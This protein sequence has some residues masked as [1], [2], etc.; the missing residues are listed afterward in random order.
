MDNTKLKEYYELMDMLATSN[1]A[2]RWI[3][4]GGKG[5]FKNIAR[6]NEFIYKSLMIFGLNNL[7][8]T[9]DF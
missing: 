9:D 2:L 7:G 8:T 1:Y 3:E 4:S 6:Q 5:N